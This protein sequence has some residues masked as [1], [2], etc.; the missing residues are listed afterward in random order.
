MK[1]SGKCKFMH[2]YGQK[3]SAGGGV[4]GLSV[5]Y[6]QLVAV[7]SLFTFLCT[8][9]GI[10]QA[11]SPLP[12]INPGNV[13]KRFKE[14]KAPP[15]AQPP[16]EVPDLGRSTPPPGADGV[17]FVLNDVQLVGNTVFGKPELEPI[18]RD[19]IGQNISLTD[20]YAIAAAISIRYRND[21]Y[22]LSRAF[23]PP[24]EINGGI[25]EIE[26]VEGYIAEIVIDGKLA[27]SD[28]QVSARL[29]AIKAS[30]P[31]QADVLERAMLGL[32]DLPSVIAQS[33][34]RPSATTEGASDLVILFEEGKKL[35]AFTS[36]DNRGSKP[37][38]RGQ[39]QGTV[40]LDNGFGV[41]ESTEIGLAGSTDLNE[42]FY[43]SA[44]HSHQLGTQGTTLG[45]FASYT[46]TEPG[47]YLSSA[48]IDGW[49]YTFS[50]S[51]AH[52]LIRSRSENLSLIGAFNITR[53]KNDFRTSRIFDSDDEIRSISL[54][55]T[56]DFID[57]FRGITLVGAELKQGLNVLN[58][59]DRDPNTTRPSASADF[60]KVVGNISRIQQLV[61]SFALSLSI[62]GQ[63]SFDDLYSSEQYGV[64]GEQ[65]GSAYDSYEIGADHGFCGRA[66]LQ[67]SSASVLVF[68]ESFEIYA[69]YDYGKVWQK[70]GDL[71]DDDLSSAGFGGR[72]NFS[73]DLWGSF[74]VAFPLTRDAEVNQSD[75]DPRLFSQ[76]SARF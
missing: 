57:R 1:S 61:P 14:D 64:G 23:V 66:E 48:D 12:S 46:E 76:V 5:A 37:L 20:F 54:G 59:S 45:L 3:I 21:G 58:A 15:K 29:D 56:Y 13:Q 18:W 55:G 43:L 52:P 19:S 39:W 35:S 75:K 50:A 49:A 33:V 70:S 7:A 8:G 11:Q 22:V 73:E 31:L 40:R 24:Q 51:V 41:Y 44:S 72:F 36:I 67:Y 10:A 25:A 60:T 69:Y 16:L 32:N 47:S 42:L 65:C 74:E 28:P 2:A 4:C 62:G 30:K 38:G 68:L 63:Y 71:L 53:S 6:R 9:Y 17:F 26:I 34:I 27:D